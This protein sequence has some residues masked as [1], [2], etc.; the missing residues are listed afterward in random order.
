MHPTS[1]KG[2]AGARLRDRMEELDR[3]KSKLLFAGLTLLRIDELYN[4]PRGTCGTTLREPNAAG[5]RAIAAVLKTKPHLL[6]RSRYHS[7][8]ARLQPQPA[9]NY[10][11]LI[12]RRPTDDSQ[13]A[14]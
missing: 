14:A 13:R 6:W 9:E 7:S 1:P 2:K 11:R 10:E 5:E 4:L 12:Q 8:G 3:I